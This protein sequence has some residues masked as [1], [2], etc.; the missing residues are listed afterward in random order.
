MP[1]PL[2]TRKSFI[3]LWLLVS[4]YLSFSAGSSG[5]WR[6]FSPEE[7]V[8]VLDQFL[9]EKKNLQKE[10]VRVY[11]RTGACPTLC[12]SSSS[13]AHSLL[14]HSFFSTTSMLF[15]SFTW[16]RLDRDTRVEIAMQMEACPRQAPAVRRCGQVSM[17]SHGRIVLFFT[18]TEEKD[19]ET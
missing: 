13:A 1:P 3:R 14:L 4:L 2:L 16:Y 6:I 18:P 11:T 17:S 12:A 7:S 19:V 10:A 5:F 8:A 9:A 15:I